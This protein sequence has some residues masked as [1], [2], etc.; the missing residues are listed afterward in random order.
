MAHTILYASI[1]FTLIS[2]LF[3]LAW[4]QNSVDEK[5]L[6]ATPNIPKSRGILTSVASARISAPA[7]EVFKAILNFKDYGKWSRFSGYEWSQTTEDGAPLVGSTGSFKVHF[8]ISV[9]PILSLS[10]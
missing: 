4:I 3:L 6:L 7:D 8:S 5:R 1:A 10:K 2:L 9:L